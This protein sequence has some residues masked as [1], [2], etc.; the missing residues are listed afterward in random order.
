MSSQKKLLILAIITSTSVSAG[1]VLAEEQ[2][3]PKIKLKV[4]EQKQKEEIPVK[5]EKEKTKTETTVKEEELKRGAGLGGVNVFRAI[6]LTPSLNIQTDD[7]YGFGGGSIRLRGFDQSQIGVTIDGMPLND[8]GNYALYPH[9]YADVEN[10]ESITVERGAVDKRNPFYVEI[11]GAVRIQTKAPSDKFGAVIFPKYGSFNMRSIFTRVDTGRLKGNIKAFV[12]YSHTEAEKWKGPGEHPKYRDHYAF[13]IQQDLGRFFWEA[14][15]DLNVQYNHFYRGL[16]YQQ[17]QDLDRFRRFD[18]TETFIFPGGD[19]LVH[20]NSTVR[21]NNQNYYGFFVNP[22]TNHQLRGKAEFYINDKLKISFNPYMWIGRGSGTS[23]V[24]F[25]RTVN[26][27]TNN[28]IAFRESYNYTDRPGFTAELSYKMNNADLYLGYWYEKAEL[29]QWQPQRPVKV[30]PDGSIT[31]I[32][33]TSGTPATFQY[34]YIQKTDTTTNSIYTFYQLNNIADKLNFNVGLRY[35]SVERDFKA[36]NTRGL[37][38]YPG[39][40]VYSDPNLTL[41]TR[42][43]YNKT[44]RRLLPSFGFSYKINDN[45]VPYFAYAQNFRVPPNFIGAVPNNVSANFVAN[46]LKPERATN[47]DLGVRFDYGRWFITPSIYYVDYKDRLIRIADPADPNLVFLRNA[48]KVEAKGLEVEF[49]ANLTENLKIYSSY[50]YNI[51]EF[52]DNCTT[53]LTGNP[54]CGIKGNQ[55]PDTP[56]NM[57]KLGIYSTVYGVNIMP[58][59]Q[60]IDSRYG[61]VD[62][63]QKVSGYTLLNMSIN[64]FIYRKN[65]QLFVDFINI[66]DKKYIGRISTGETNGTYFVGAPFTMSVGLRGSF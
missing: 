14:Y 47:Y 35:A 6:E 24:T 22:Y 58:S 12:S 62:N 26:N 30:N 55:V 52:K 51:A 20:N 54:V 43:S 33:A 38:F 50:S 59:L 66:T 11:G 27:Q 9:E 39:D 48:G 44:Y 16:T 46:Q 7:A 60:Y 1:Q 31:L 3:K 29:K 45:I 4:E 49:G 10:L 53:L 25:T 17:A 63:K 65:L 56:K 18:Y 15:Y 57:F 28:Y 42:L 19:G 13:G 61:T 23:G 32:T 8:S 40:G 37:P 41:D 5:P 21:A 2:V 64:S 36:Y 34:N